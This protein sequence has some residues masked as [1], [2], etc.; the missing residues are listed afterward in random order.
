M[1]AVGNIIVSINSV[2]IKIDSVC[3]YKN[4]NTDDVRVGY[5]YIARV[6]VLS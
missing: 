3:C 1:Q 5:C 6:G 4:H 2:V